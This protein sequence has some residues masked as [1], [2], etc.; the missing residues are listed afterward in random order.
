MK[1]ILITM[2]LL[3]SGLIFMG[4]TYTVNLSGTVLIENSDIP[5][6]QA[7]VMI[8]TD[9]LS[10][11]FMYF[12]VVYTDGNGYYEDSFDVPDGVEGTLFV[13]TPNCDGIMLTEDVDFSENYTELEVYFYVCDDP[14]GGDCE[15]MFNYYPAANDWLT[16]QFMDASS[17]YPN[18]W[19]WDFGDGNTSTDQN[20]LHTYD[21][22]GDYYVNLTISDDSSDCNSS[23][24]LLVRVGDTIWIPDSC[25]AWFFACPDSSDFMTMHFQDMS[26]GMYNEQP[27]SW[28]WEFGDGSTSDEQNPV[29]TY[30]QEDEYEVCLT[31]TFGDV[32]ESSYCEIIEVID[33]DSYCQAQFYYF[34]MVDSMPDGG[35]FAI[36]FMDYSYG[37]PTEWE[38]EFG[39]G[40]GSEEQNPIHTYA[41]EGTYNVCLTIANPADSCES[42]YCQDI[43]VFNDTMY[44]CYAWFEYEIEELTVDFEGY[45][46]NSQS[47]DY[48][49]DF[50]DNATG[51]GQQV[52][53]TYSED[54]EYYV[55]M[56]VIDSLNDC[57]TTYTEP[58]WV[59]DWT[60]DITGYVYM[61]D[62]VSAD[63][64]TVYLMTYDT[65]DQVLV[66][67]DETEVGGDYG[68]YSFEDVSGENFIYYVQA[69][70]TDMS[71]YYGDYAPT[72][73]FN[74]LNWVDAW[75][76]IAYPNGYN[77]YDIL[78]IP[79]QNYN[80][81]SGL[82]SGFVTNQ[83]GRSTMENV[84]ILLLDES[85]NPLTYNK[86]GE[87][88]DFD[89]SE[90]AFGTYIV[91]TEM[92][93]IQTTPVTVTL[94]EDI[95]EANINIVVQNGE[96][97]LS[98]G[99]AVSAYVGEVSDVYPN[100][101]N[102]QA[103]INIQT[104]QNANIDITV[105][106]S[107]GTVIYQTE[108]NY[109]PGKQRFTIETQSLPKGIYFISVKSSDGFAKVRKLVKL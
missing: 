31:A 6:V 76:I 77:R 34:P 54:G 46:D 94:T 109:S 30:A 104:K 42:T 17:G 45:L 66:A 13:S 22:F 101:S 88:G 87:D 82:I 21:D 69:E 59:G 18:N 33:W 56:T 90:L 35:D 99:D 55:T 73:H 84:E 8:Q 103:H 67:V 32:C 102:G 36:Q 19:S 92:V 107:L 93:G 74:A 58:I 53:H 95:P 60:F 24:E 28:S 15:A 25:M 89:F 2:T 83:D 85:G 9:S 49:W 23:V 72:Y 97:V 65:V 78:M 71:A 3:L 11:D 64:A 68:Y 79:N 29:H 5:V 62:S 4:Q 48:Y 44:D 50:G 80:S 38:W 40:S 16:I 108:Q 57:M 20:P 61:E 39:D 63:Y 100:P 10:G 1:K 98:I 96:A 51:E 52:S 27:T 7:P 81:G 26:F 14:S 37:N 105:A 43:Y 91:Y 86:T 75:P 47:G 70:L 106:N 12:T 41:S